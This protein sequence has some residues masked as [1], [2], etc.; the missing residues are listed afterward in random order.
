M[1]AG[2]ELSTPSMITDSGERPSWAARLFALLAGF[3]LL[4]S[5]LS[6]PPTDDVMSSFASVFQADHLDSP[7]PENVYRSW[8]Q[9]GIG[10]RYLIYALTH[11]A[12]LLTDTTRPARFEL[13]VKVLYYGL[14]LLLIAASCRAAR[15]ALARIGV[16]PFDAFAVCALGILTCSQMLQMQAEELAVVLALAMTAAAVSDSRRT[17]WLSGLFVPLLFS[18]KFLTVAYAVLP[19]A[20]LLALVPIRRAQLLRVLASSAAGLAATVA[21]WTVFLPLELTSARNAALLQSALKYSQRGV[22]DGF[23]WGLGRALQHAP[24]LIPG[25]ALGAVLALRP[26]SGAPKRAALLGGMFLACAAVVIVQSKWFPYHFAGFLLFA[27]LVCG[28]ALALAAPGRRNRWFAAIA[29]LTLFGWALSILILRDGP[30]RYPDA[31]GGFYALVRYEPR[32]R[33]L[34]EIESRFALGREESMLFLSDGTPNYVIR[35]RSYLPYYYPLPLQRLRFNPALAST[36][37]HRSQLAAALAYR[38]EYVLLE[39]AWFDL[40]LLP[41]LERKLE[42]EYEPVFTASRTTAAMDTVLLRRRP[43]A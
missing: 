11:A 42:T 23:G 43:G 20:V 21:I 25:L 4:A 19:V 8:H 2:A 13:T 9:R 38:G 22:I 12:A 5:V 3:V 10:Y 32:M 26:R 27:Y 34:R 1:N 15:S 41:E 35:C 7:F 29:G 37:L 28:M 39:P 18:C 16:T 31:N 33:M 40:K 30:L 6:T 24:F 36:E 14:L 17:Q